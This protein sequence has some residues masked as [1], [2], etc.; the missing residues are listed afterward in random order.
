MAFKPNVKVP[1]TPL[2][3]NARVPVRPLE[4]NSYKQGYK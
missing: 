2:D 4:K 1:G 3:P